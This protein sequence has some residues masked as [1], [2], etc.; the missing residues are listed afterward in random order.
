MKITIHSG[1]PLRAPYVP[2]A[3]GN[4]DLSCQIDFEGVMKQQPYCGMTPGIRRA[5]YRYDNPTGTLIPFGFF[6]QEMEGIGA[7]AEWSQSFDPRNGVV[8]TDCRY[9]DGT[10]IRSTVFCNLNS[11]VIVIRKT[12]DTGR[13]APFLLNYHFA[14]KRTAIRQADDAIEYTADGMREYHGRIVFSCDAPA[15]LHRE[16]GLWRLATTARECT[17]FLAFDGAEE[18]NFEALLQSTRHAWEAFLQEGFVRIPSEKLQR[19]YESSIYHLRI[20]TTAWSIPTGIFDTHWNGLYFGF[21]E[22]FN[23]LGLLSA[24]HLDL[25]LRVPRF[26]SS[27][28]PA[29]RSRSNSP[30]CDRGTALFP[31]ETNEIGGEN[32]PRGFWYEHIFHESHFV[33]EAWAG[34]RYSGDTEL[35]RREF[36][37]LIRGCAEYLRLHHVTYDAAGRTVI[38]ACTDLERLGP[39][40]SNP[41]MTSCSVI[42]AFEAAADAADVLAADPEL[43][44]LWRELAAEL[45][46]SLP[47]DGTRHVPYAGCETHSIAQLAG[48]FPYGVLSGDD[49]LQRNAIDDYRKHRDLCGNMYQLGS[50]ICSWYL[51]WE[52]AAM[53]RLGKTG[54]ALT[55][56]EAIADNCGNW[57]E[58]FEIREVEMRPYFTT[59]AGCFVFAI[60]ELL[61]RFR[62]GLPLPGSWRDF[63]FRLSGPHAQVIE[64]EFSGGSLK[65][66]TEEAAR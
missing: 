42:A 33:L 22:Y 25:A 5:G 30:K 7:L 52:A 66:I 51:A 36:Y 55:I 63:S 61:L 9:A 21:D 24:G 26:R 38:G 11:N 3:I 32:S 31:W 49:P 58:M 2:P 53:V 20:S 28:L 56:L 60:N 10:R 16:S 50:G 41:F 14:P 19:A 35:L 59:A 54:E 46:A 15:E 64:V 17:F 44:Q 27:L 13:T 4:G 62:N 6:T 43:S 18:G 29:A 39:A 45:R 48:V 37:P 40:V 8:D 34:Y 23:M 1:D 57:Y 12:I 47:H 65:S